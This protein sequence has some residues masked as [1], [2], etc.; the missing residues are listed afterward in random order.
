MKYI[1]IFV[2]GSLFFSTNASFA[3][4]TLASETK[5]VGSYT[6][7]FNASA[8]AGEIVAGRPISYN[9]LLTDSKTKEDVTFDSVYITFLKKGNG[10]NQDVI[11]AGQLVNASEFFLGN[12]LELALPA[13]G[14]YTAEVSFQR[15]DKIERSKD[16][17]TTSFDVFVTVGETTEIK[18]PT[19]AFD[20][21]IV[22]GAGAIAVA[23]AFF[24]GRVGKRK[25]K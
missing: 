24:L 22:Y 16:I 2:V 14:E 11:F 9:F 19:K 23:I 17:A 21:R 20:T 7:E 4:G 6:V 1:L 10:D 8:D 3:H 5:K 15:D 12:S 25:S 13:P 18:T